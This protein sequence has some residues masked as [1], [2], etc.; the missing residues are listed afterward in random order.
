MKRI[1]DLLLVLVA[2]PFWLPLFILLW[3][4]VRI[5]LGSPAFFRQKRAGKDGKSFEIIKF[6]TMRDLRDSDHKLLP[7][8]ARLTPFGKRL[9]SLSLDELPELFNVLCGDMSL[10]GPRPLPV[11]YLD[12]YSTE[13]A[14]RHEC[15]PGIT[16]W[17]QVNGRNQVDWD[18][19]FQMD[20][21]YVDHAGLLL[22][23][24]ILWKTVSTVFSREGISAENTVTMHEFT[25][26]GTSTGGRSLNSVPPQSP[27]PSHKTE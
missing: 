3:L 8:E 23:L 21:W 16:G 20:V 11:V 17:A 2:L 12:R 4:T 25:G 27:D 18:E 19:R 22:D 5:K 6:R 13:Q 1:L 9:R 15:R 10:V 24:K 7:D 26:P 14:R